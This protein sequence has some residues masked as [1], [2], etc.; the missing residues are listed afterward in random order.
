MKDYLMFMFGAFTGV[1]MYM[2][3]ESLSKNK[4]T[5]KKKMNEMI[6]TYANVVEK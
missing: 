4:N 5:I 2:G 3:L 6:D 1:S